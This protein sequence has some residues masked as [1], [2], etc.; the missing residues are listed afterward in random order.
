MRRIIA[1]AGL[2]MRTAIRSR[3]LM[4]AACG[5]ALAVFGLPAVLHG[6][7]TLGGQVQLLLYYPL[8]FTGM[9]LALGAVWAG[10][11]MVAVEVDRGT[12]ALLVTKPVRPIELW[13]GKWLGLLVWNFAI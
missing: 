5:V 12:A 9:L 8:G 3:L 13:L 11:A 10:A 4:L 1:I 6:D 7:G 2:T